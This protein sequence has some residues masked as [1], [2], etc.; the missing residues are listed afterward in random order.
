MIFK[1]EI[2]TEKVTYEDN[3]NSNIAHAIEICLTNV[4]TALL[5]GQMAGNV[6]DRNGNPVGKYFFEKEG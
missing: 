6:R 4:A 2:K 5:G 3:E 1:I